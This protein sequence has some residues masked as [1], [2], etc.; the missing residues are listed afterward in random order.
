M[1]R[2]AV[3]V[4][5]SM[6]AAS[7][8]EG[9]C[10][11]AIQDAQKLED[12]INEV[13][14]AVAKGDLLDEY[15][16]G[17]FPAAKNMNKLVWDCEL[18]SEAA[19]YIDKCQVRKDIKKN[20]TGY[21]WSHESSL[22]RIGD[23]KLLPITNMVD[24]LLNYKGYITTDLDETVAR[25]P[26]EPLLESTSVDP[27]FA[28][29]IAAAATKVGCAV[30]KCDYEGEKADTYDYYATVLCLTDHRLESPDYDI[31]EIK[32]DEADCVCLTDS[33]C[34]PDTKLCETT[35]TITTTTTTPTTTTTTPAIQPSPNAVLPSST[36]EDTICP[37]N[38]YMTDKLRLRILDM[39]NSRRS[40]L[41][42]GNVTKNTGANLPAAA[43][44]RKL[45]YDCELEFSAIKFASQ[46][47]KIGSTED[48]R[49]E[50]GENMYQMIETGVTSFEEAASKAVDSWWKVVQVYPSPGSAAK[51]RETHVGTAIIT[52][53]QMAWAATQYLGCS[54]VNC[55]PFY[56]TVC[57]YS[58]KGNVVGQTVYAPGDFC[59]ACP[60]D[61]KCN[62]TLY[63]CA[64]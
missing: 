9:I 40:S 21:G 33:W 1:T 37:E 36:T 52:F 26:G 60:P 31:Y 20:V 6:L 38:Y 46:C 57:R 56:T 48:T 30:N 50:Q 19:T 62:A 25:L 23:E 43:N 15:T 27:S 11:G 12:S 29:L 47:P 34:N 16:G 53:T 4:I 39:H 17:T 41:A 32:Q 63:L 5:L 55:S 61:T 35:T 54:V 24:E 18:Q 28:N 2:S 64:P 13:R 8:V 45:K 59:T 22:H 3:I 42:L 14:A 58:P 49:V 44:M 10:D 51:F 7:S